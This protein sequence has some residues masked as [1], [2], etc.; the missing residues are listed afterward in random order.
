MKILFW[1]INYPNSVGEITNACL[2]AQKIASYCDIYFYSSSLLAKNYISSF[3]FKQISSEMLSEINFSLV[4]FSEYYNIFSIG[5]NLPDNLKA[6]NFIKNNNL[7][8][9]S[10]DTLGFGST[11]SEIKEKNTLNPHLFHY[12]QDLFLPKN[13]FYAIQPCPLNNPWRSKSSTTFSWL[14][15]PI[16][17]EKKTNERALNI[18]FPFSKWK[19]FS[20]QKNYPELK[21][22]EELKNYFLSA[23]SKMSSSQKINFFL[24]T[25][26]PIYQ[27][28]EQDFLKLYFFDPNAETYLE[29]LLYEK[30]LGESDLVFT[31]NPIQNS[32]VRSVIA[33]IKGI[34]L[35]NN[36]F[37]LPNKNPWDSLAKVTINSFYLPGRYP[38]EKDN[39]YLKMFNT[40]ELFD[41]QL[42][43][44][45]LDYQIP[46]LP[47]ENKVYIEYHQS[48]LTEGEIV[49]RILDYR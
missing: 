6:L 16:K 39:P 15:P 2:F 23:F 7:P 22:L 1:I 44:F 12:Y 10:L 33:G 27:E 24:G 9:A 20:W 19:F 31:F 40:L 30:L 5:S 35:T 26:A 47:S 3:A 36:V 38:L 14:F 29:P 18:F 41:P 48:C 13:K 34:N 42:I 21:M 45:L 11:T 25:P 46:V 4:I 17:R 43:S 32:F 8:V 49:N 28:Y 37:S